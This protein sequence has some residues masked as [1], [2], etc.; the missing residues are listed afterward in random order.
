MI[1]LKDNIP[2]RTTPFVN[3]TIIGLCALVF[4][5]QLRETKD[6][7]SLVEKYGMI[8]ARISHPG[9][10]VEIPVDQ[11]IVRTPTGPQVRLIKREAAPSAVP[12]PLTL[13]TCIFLHGGWMH[14]IGN[15]WFLYIFGD[16]VEDRFGHL[17]YVLFYLGCGIAAS[18][19]H[20]LTAPGSAMPTIGASGAIAGVMGAYFV[21]Y[22]HARVLTLLPLFIIWEILVLPAGFF[23]GFWFLIQ[24]VQGSMTMGGEG[25]GVAW[26]AHIG[27]FVAGV[28]VTLILD[29][30][31]LL[32][33]R[34]DKIRPRTDHMRMYRVTP[35][36]GGWS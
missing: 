10:P 18:L 33:P 30:L 3:H 7:P 27:G 14:F 20:Y 5:L 32:R 24:F 29:R 8:P 34:V 19:A 6:D 11:V 21:S 2:S 4:F 28:A 36:R 13:L 1:P 26:W 23:L 35:G 25:A 17:G 15:M 16:N 31:H 12:A 9:E 22:P